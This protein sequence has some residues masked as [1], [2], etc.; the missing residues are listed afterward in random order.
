MAGDSNGCILLREYSDMLDFSQKFEFPAIFFKK[1]LIRVTL[2]MQNHW[3]VTSSLHTRAQI[4]RQNRA[5][6]NVAIKFKFPAKIFENFSGKLLQDVQLIMPIILIPLSC[7]QLARFPNVLIVV[8]KF[9]VVPE[10]ER[11][12]E[13]GKPEEQ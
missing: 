10:G 5:S 1:L 4:C 8:N 7:M 12:A 11:E 9:P 2:H 6:L 3:Y 13:E